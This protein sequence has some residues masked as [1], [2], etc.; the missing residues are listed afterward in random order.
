VGGLLLVSGTAADDNQFPLMDR[1][2]NVTGYRP[3][4]AS[5]ASGLSANYDYD[6]FGRELKST[7]VASDAMPFRFSTKYTDGESGLVYYGYRFLD[8]EKGRWVSRDPIGE[9][10]GINVTNFAG[11]DCV[12]KYDVL[13]LQGYPQYNPNDYGPGGRFSA[14]QHCCDPITKK[15]KLYDK[16]TQCCKDGVITE[17]KKRY[18]WMRM[19]RSDC[20]KR[21]MSDYAWFY[22]V[23]GVMNG[24]LIDIIIA[25]L[26][27]G[28]GMTPNATKA[29]GKGV[30]Y[31]ASFAL[32][33]WAAGEMCDQ[34]F[35]SEEEHWNDW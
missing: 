29:V 35:C 23:T 30:G 10:G 24:A 5:P 33:H 25:E 31:S 11:S 4:S 19:T 26:T 7:G 2:G 3:A 13:G 34:R 28:A 27:A 18:E 20:I 8:T 14:S 9:F 15:S 12:N 1:M 17:Q 16:R 6:A 22:G 21:R 32:A